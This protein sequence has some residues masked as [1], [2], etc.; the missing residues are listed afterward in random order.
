MSENESNC[1]SMQKGCVVERICTN[2]YVLC[3]E[4][5]LS[6]SKS[7]VKTNSDVDLV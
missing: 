5:I 7:F 3:F 6:V 4:Y 1:L 2:V